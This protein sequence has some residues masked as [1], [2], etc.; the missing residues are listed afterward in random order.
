VK[1]EMK[2][3][4]ILLCESTQKSA[5][6]YNNLIWT[7]FSVGVALSLWILYKVWP[8]K[9]NIGFM[10]LFMLFVGFLVL[11]YCTL[12][13]ESFGQ[14]KT[15]MHEIFYKELKNPKF[16]KSIKNLPYEK[17]EWVAEFI[18]SIIFL[19]YI[20]GFFWIF[21]DSILKNYI[22]QFK[23]LLSSVFFTI[24]LCLFFVVLLN[25]VRRPRLLKQF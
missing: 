4:E 20:C 9:E 12:A 18:L 2:N 21:V 15:K 22:Y 19:S 23:T 16:K 1:S 25:W 10:N 14:K 8:S 13:I 7:V 5:E 6:H 17:L 24:A 3:E 11:Y